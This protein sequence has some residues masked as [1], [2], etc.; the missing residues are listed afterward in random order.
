MSFFLIKYV[1]KKGK[2]IDAAL[3][4]KNAGIVFALL[5]ISFLKTKIIVSAINRFIRNV[6]KNTINDFKFLTL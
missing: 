3:L 6:I 1:I 2:I 4:I 5:K